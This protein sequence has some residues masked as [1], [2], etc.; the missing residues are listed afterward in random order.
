MPHPFP[1]VE[2]V[3]YNRLLRHRRTPSCQLLGGLPTLGDD[4]PPGD[5]LRGQAELGWQVIVVWECETKIREG[6]AVKLRAFPCEA[7]ASS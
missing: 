5:M 4:A 6:L 2:E 3:A 7:P 1:S